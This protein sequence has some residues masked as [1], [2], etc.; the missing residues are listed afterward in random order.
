MILGLI[1]PVIGYLITKNEV[2]YP[3]GDPRGEPWYDTFVLASSF[4]IGALLFV[5][6]LV[7]LWQARGGGG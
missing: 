5:V 4:L 1:T 7:R 3:A 2:I 6:G